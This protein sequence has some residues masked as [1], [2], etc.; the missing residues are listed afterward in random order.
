LGGLANVDGHDATRVAIKTD[1]R[2]TRS[3]RAI[4]SLGAT[5]EGVRAALFAG[6]HLMLDESVPGAN[7]QVA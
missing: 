5:R 1:Q 3:Q 7:W 2:N 6:S 4:E